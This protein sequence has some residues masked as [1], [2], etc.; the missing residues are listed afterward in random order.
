MTHIEDVTQSVQHQHVDDM[1]TEGIVVVDVRD[2]DR[3][4]RKVGAS[5]G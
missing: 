5:Q 1:S 2:A 4:A 3:L